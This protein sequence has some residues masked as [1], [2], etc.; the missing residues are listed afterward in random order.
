MTKQPTDLTSRLQRGE[1]VIDAG[2]IAEAIIRRSRVETFL[3]SRLAS[4]LEAR[5]LDRMPGGVDQQRA[6][7]GPDLA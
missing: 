4:V 6:G 1:Y 7:A 2:A 5:E 3:G